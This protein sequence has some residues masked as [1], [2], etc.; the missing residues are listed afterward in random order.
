MFTIGFA[1]QMVNPEASFDFLIKPFASRYIILDEC[2]ILEIQADHIVD[3]IQGCNLSAVI[4]N[5]REQTAA[6]L[7]FRL[8]INH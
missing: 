6:G 3:S 5:K 4:R 1:N 2:R 8:A 7:I